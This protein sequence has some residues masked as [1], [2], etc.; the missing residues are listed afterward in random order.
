MRLVALGACIAFGAS[1]VS[2][3]SGCRLNFDEV[4]VDP[5]ERCV[6]VV[7]VASITSGRDFSCALLAD[8]GV[9]C[10]GAGESGQLG[11]G[12]RSTRVDPVS[13]LGLGAATMV[14]AGIQ[15]ACAVVDGSV[16]CWGRNDAAQLGLGDRMSRDVPS[17]VGRLTAV[18]GVS[19]GGLHTCAW[20][21]NGE[22]YCW[23]QGNGTPG[24]SSA[25]PTRV[26]GVPA[27]ASAATSS[28]DSRFSANHGCAIAT[29]GS[30]WCWGSNNWGQLGNGSS[31]ESPTPV[32][33]DTSLVFV[34][35]G[36]GYGH[37]CG[38]TGDGV[39]ACW[40]LGVD[41]EIGDGATESRSVPVVIAVP[42]SAQIAAYEETTCSR[43]RDG[44]VM[45]WGDN[46][47]EQLARGGDDALVPERIDVPASHAISVGKNHACAIAGD[48]VVRCWGSD[49]AGLRSGILDPSSAY[50]FDGLDAAQIAA[51]GDT[52]CA[53]G[54]DGRVRCW[55]FNA[56]GQL[57]DGTHTSR[58]MPVDIGLANVTDISVGADHAC[59]RR[60]DASVVCWG[61][62]EN[63]RILFGGGEGYVSPTLVE[64]IGISPASIAAGGGHTCAVG[65]TGVPWCWGNSDE[66]TLG[67]PSTAD[68]VSRPVASSFTNVTRM[69]AGSNHTCVVTAANQVWC[70]GRD[71]EGQIGRSDNNGDAYQPLEVIGAPSATMVS[72]GR[73]HTCAI[74]TSGGGWCWGNNATGQLGDGT[75]TLAEEPVALSLTGL[76]EVVAGYEHTCARDAANTV[77]CWGANTSEQLGDLTFT[78]RLVPTRSSVFSGARQLALGTSHTCALVA[79]GSVV[80]TGTRVYGQMATGAVASPAPVAVGLTC[81]R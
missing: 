61:S 15:H 16:W 27:I 29:D 33:V 75:D 79:G 20:T 51:G 1:V 65:P 32:R 50:T 8:G 57:G 78:T 52:T 48:G 25:N 12:E 28:A 24:E 71:N 17:R 55:G 10:W 37:A 5:A 53:R 21:A 44:G 19:A 36:L 18:V 2:V 77:W 81:P 47:R 67:G 56:A 3:A 80:C 43:D 72:A 74:S 11:D 69:S 4:E 40:G 59:A 26:S 60:G 7:D 31:I 54:N 13:P 23:G 64:S 39:V 70:S 45:C 34:E 41:G 68:G 62:N 30:A 66:G 38:R 63:D 73:N 6:P 76:V 22:L 9:R 14:S 46:D 58:A 42:L 35:I 49:R